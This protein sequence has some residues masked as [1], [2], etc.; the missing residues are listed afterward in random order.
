MGRLGSGSVLSSMYT[1]KVQSDVIL[2]VLPSNLVVIVCVVVSWTVFVVTNISLVLILYTQG[3]HQTL[4]VII[5]I[6]H[7]DWAGLVSGSSSFPC[8]VKCPLFLLFFVAVCS[9]QTCIQ[10]FNESP[11]LFQNSFSVLV[12]VFLNLVQADSLRVRV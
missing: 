11:V 4:T 9:M 5:V 7:L 12:C 3:R 10:V 6:I 1:Y 8:V 2:T